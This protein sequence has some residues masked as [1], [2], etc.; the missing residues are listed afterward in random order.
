MNTL[1]RDQRLQQ[2]YR[3]ARVGLFVHWGMLTGVHVTDPMGPALRYP[4]ETPEA[5]EK[6]TVTA[7]WNAE[8]WVTTAKRLNAQY[9]TVATFHCDL[10]YLK[11]WPS[12][13][14]GSPSTQR[15]YLKEL[16]EAATPEGVRIIVYI[17]RAA[18]HAYHGGVQW[19]DRD[20]YRRYKGD[21]AVDITT[22][23]GFLRYTMDLVE[24][25]LETHSRIA[26]FW[27]DG[28]N[29][30][31]EAQ[32]VFSRIHRIRDDVILI[33]NNFGDGPVAD[34]D[35]M[36]L[37]DW[38]KISDPEFDFA[39]ATWVA[40][41]D[42]EFAFKAKADW[43][44]LGAGRPDWSNYELNYA[45]E[46]TN[47]TIV[48]RI[49]TIAGSSWNAHLGYGPK[50]GGDFPESLESFTDHFDRFMSWACESI[51]GTVG[52]GY[53]DGGFPPGLWN[54]GAYG[55]TTVIPGQGIHYLHVLRPPRSHHLVL[56][57]AGYTVT[58][59]S[60][61]KTGQGLRYEQAGGWLTVVV[62]S[63]SAVEEDG[64]LIVKLTTAAVRSL[65]S[66]SE[67]RVSASS[68]MP[69][70]PVANLLNGD[71]HSYFQAADGPWPKRVTM[72]LASPR[73]VIGLC[74]TQPETG[75]VRSGGYAAPISERIKEYEVHVS[76]DGKQWGE[77]VRSGE[78][79]NRRGLQVILFDPTLAASV[80]LTAR[81]NYGKTKALKLIALELI[82]DGAQARR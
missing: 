47:A 68:E 22:G 39:S 66:R 59:A 6:A 53:G 73:E 38:G 61:L 78:L 35:A 8:R 12:R 71:Y 48:R 28:Y 70:H 45:H 20:A 49:L 55:V 76:P 34:E 54:E 42:K 82:G 21:D 15:D 77:P 24:E 60:N 30:P 26:G 31:E 67:I 65:I 4:Y 64:A 14:P 29:D 9:L 41:G 50:I 1:T 46:P 2:W 52:G 11:I 75:P 63:W 13:V 44:Y 74:L 57:D 25:L 58:A 27:F 36:S 72:S 79:S 18:H 81:G 5:F 33:R 80:R 16:L 69:A 23:P 32:A 40:P 19:L 43:F 17:T 10:G 51:Y 7:G 37:E 3:Q 56:P 62:P